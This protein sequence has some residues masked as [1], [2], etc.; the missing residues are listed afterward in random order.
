[1]PTIVLVEAI[2]AT[3]AL[4]LGIDGVHIYYMLGISALFN[5]LRFARGCFVR[6]LVLVLSLG[7]SHTRTFDSSAAAP[8]RA[9]ALSLVRAFASFAA[10]LAEAELD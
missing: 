4:G 6:Y 7:A 1:M 8:E 9:T 3:F 5:S 10:M 2:G